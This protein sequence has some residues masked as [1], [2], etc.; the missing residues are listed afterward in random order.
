MAHRRGKS[1]GAALNMNEADT[2]ARV[3]EGSVRQLPVAVE[4]FSVEGF[5]QSEQISHG[6][7]VVLHRFPPCS[8]LRRGD[9]AQSSLL[10]HPH[11]FDH[12]CRGRDGRSGIGEVIDSRFLGES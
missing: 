1:A 3:A 5:E 7:F 2:A 10:S 6:T 9:I 4:G 11:R 12:P 8:R